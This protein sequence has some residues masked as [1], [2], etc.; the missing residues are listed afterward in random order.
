[1]QHH[2]HRRLPAHGV[3]ILLGSIS[4][5]A[6]FTATQESAPVRPE[7]G[8]EGVE[9]LMRGPIHEAFA[10]VVDFAPQPGI[11]ASK[12]PPQRILEQ[13]PDQRPDSDNVAWIPGYW[14][15]D[16]ERDDFIWVS[17]VW[18]A[19]PP[20]RQWIAGYWA[21]TDRGYQWISGYWIE[22]QDGDA[23]EIDYLPQ[24]PESLE[25]GPSS[26]APTPDHV[27]S[28]GCWVWHTGRYMWRPGYWLLLG[29]DWLWVP[30]HYRWAPRGY[31]FVDGYWDYVVPRRGILYA[32]LYV[33]LRIYRPRV[34][35]PHICININVF[36]RH[37]F[38]RPYFGHYYF[39]DYYGLHYYDH[40]FYASFSFASGRYGCEPI[41]M[42][43]R[44]QNRYQPNWDHHEREDFLHR[45]EHENDRPPRT[46]RDQL[47]TRERGNVKDPTVIIAEPMED[48]ARKP[49]L[50]A[51]VRPTTQEE[52]REILQ[53]D[54]RIESFRQERQRVEIEPQ[55]HPGK[56]PEAQPPEPK[57][58]PEAQPQRLRLPRSPIVSKPGDQLDRAHTPP[59]RPHVPTSDP[60]IEPKPRQSP[61][62]PKPES[63]R[64]ADTKTRPSVPT[65]ARP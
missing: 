28:P 4:V 50:P 16:D 42:H 25:A 18:R 36:P 8:E 11:I 52:T 58:K 31:I 33:D 6:N 30:A 9:V 35:R 45:R 63:P 34:Y 32:P 62:T 60:R 49:N 21:E 61:S 17:G 47:N 2:R 43:T 40:G 37:L 22:T 1:M 12:A 19:M 65:S 27:W 48:M 53:R 10:E 44:W 55:R 56:P 7:T 3:L 29:P 38:V 20:G 39:G 5:N 24:P 41:Y 46:W 57:P 26:P 64:R 54:G 23:T 59:Q 13:P 15:W 51:R 14:A